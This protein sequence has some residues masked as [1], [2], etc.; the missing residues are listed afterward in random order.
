MGHLDVYTVHEELEVGHD[1]VLELL[2]SSVRCR[3]PAMARICT[4]LSGD[5]SSDAGAHLLLPLEFHQCV[6]KNGAAK[7]SSTLPYGARSRVTLAVSS[8]RYDPRRRI[9]RMGRHV[10]VEVI[11]L[12]QLLLDFRTIVVP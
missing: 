6:W 10:F 11:W 5:T 2:G 12:E 1:L 7:R 9:L 8:A 4:S 3:V